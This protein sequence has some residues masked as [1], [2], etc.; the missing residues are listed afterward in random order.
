MILAMSNIAW[1]PGERLAAYAILAEAGFTGL[2]IAPGLFF[3]AAA[4]PFVPDAASA[5]EAL[6]EIADAGLALVSMQSLLFGVEGAALFGGPEA[7]AAF[8]TGMTRAIRLA[9]EFG[10]PHLVFG[11]PLQ[12][13]VPEGLAM[14]RAV[15]EAAAVFRRLADTAVAAGTRIGIEANPAAYGTKFCTTL[16]AALGF[17]ALV[18][19]PAVV[20][21][22]DIGAMHMNGDFAEL[23]ARLPALAPRLSHVHVSEPHLAPA[24]ADPATLA[25][26]LHA[27]SAAGYARAVSIEMKRPEGGLA[28]VRAAVTRLSQAA[29]AA[30]AIDA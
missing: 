22:L 24:P 17:V 15:G 7:R 20:A 27:L 14:D 26:V 12:R 3:H 6:A 9:G 2:E 28:E 8:E 25:P 4:D 29:R 5:R 18:D 13:R 19:H 1:A 11:S 30:E 23:A 21:H 16:E 10:I